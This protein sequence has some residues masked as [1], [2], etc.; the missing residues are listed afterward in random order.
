[1]MKSLC[2]YCKNAILAV[3]LIH[4]YIIPAIFF[5]VEF[6]ILYLIIITSLYIYLCYCRELLEQ[7]EKRRN[8]SLFSVGVLFVKPVQHSFYVYKAK[9]FNRRSHE[10]YDL[11]VNP[12]MMRIRSHRFNGYSFYVGPVAKIP[13]KSFCQWSARNRAVLT[14]CFYPHLTPM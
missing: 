7:E 6:F 10:Y 13:T 9:S 3:C 12:P 11:L 2:R 5:E 8:R 4:A 14:Y 1:M